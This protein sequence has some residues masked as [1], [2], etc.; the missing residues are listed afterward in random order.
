MTGERRLIVNADGYGFGDGATRGVAD[1]VVGGGVI[2]SI[3]VNA[4]FPAVDHLPGFLD[5]QPQISVG[6]HLNPL[7]GRPCLPPARVA[8]LVRPDG[9]FL[10]G[11]FFRRLRAGAVDMGELRAEFEA[12]IEKVAGLAGARLTHLDSQAH[13]HLR[14]FDLF[15]DLARKWRIQRIRTNASMICLE[16]LRPGLTRTLAYVARPHVWAVHQ[17]RK[18]QMRRAHRA[19]LRTA[20]ALVTV[21]YAGTGNKTNVENW[22]RILQNLPRGTFEIFCHPAYPDETLRRWSTYHEP[23]ARE[24]AVLRDGHLREL[25]ERL[26]IKLIS[27]SEV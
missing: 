12:Q 10:E 22:R 26:G 4:N 6:V 5:R 11:E 2:T 16:A 9:Y 13:S 15:L 24:F 1:A 19:G 8:S 17:F 20:D 23:R 3:S 21:G 27:F 7:A 14:Y 25:A 18:W